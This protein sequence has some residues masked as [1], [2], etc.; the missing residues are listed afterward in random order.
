MKRLKFSLSRV[1]GLVALAVGTVGLLA[2]CPGQE[3]KFKILKTIP[4]GGEGGWDYI[5]VDAEAR[6]LYVPRTKHLQV[7][8]LDKG[9]IIKDIPDISAKGAHGVALAPAQNLGFVTAG[10]D[11]VAIAFDLKTFDIKKK[12]P[13]GDN[14]DP[15]LYDPASKHIFVMNHSGG[16]VTVID[17]AN[18]EQTPDTIAI[19]GKI[20]AACSD[21]AGHVFV[22]VEDKNEIV[23]I[24]S[25]ENKVLAHWPVVP[26]ADPSSVAID[27][28][29]NRL[30]VGC[31]NE[32]MAV[33]DAKTGKVL[34]TPTIGKDVDGVIFDPVLKVAMASAVEGNVS[35]VK[36]TS[37]GKFETIQT[38]KTFA[39]AKTIALDSATHQVLLPCNIPEANDSKK[40]TF[41]IVVIGEKK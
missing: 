39:G 28:E 25:K 15:I 13:T 18:L 7:V 12:I 36:E 6:R 38:V 3:E 40:L 2:G 32:M 31:G 37:P 14:A 19:G 29:H 20:E 4:L 41:G 1:V 33:L 30:F 27:T 24:D 8:D 17:P 26:G 11:N 21:G 9:T 10:R 23:Q 5:Y 34:G 35:V 22:C 16:D